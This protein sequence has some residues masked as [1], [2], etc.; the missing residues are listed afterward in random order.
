MT[1]TLPLL[2]AR[3]DIADRNGQVLASTQP[4]VAVTADPT[5]TGPNAP[6]IAAVLAPYLQLTPDQLI[7]LLSTPKTRFVY[8]KKQVPALTYAA[9]SAE[10]SRAKL[11]G[12]F[13]EADPVRS[14]PA[15]AVGASTVGFVG[16]GRAGP[17]R[18][19]AESE[20]RAGRSGRG[21]R[22]SRARP[23]AARSRSVRA[24]SPRLATG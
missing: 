17:G 7:P 9:L 15:G 8:L 4:A 1:R 22:R 21:P 2:P 11:Y 12:V 6:Q 19:G 24:P 16:G 20:S 13:R 10:L 14:Y 18:T 23:T 5:L 3:G